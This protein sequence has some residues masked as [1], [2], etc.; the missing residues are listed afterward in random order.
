M[1]RNEDGLSRHGQLFDDQF[2]RINR[3]STD[4]SCNLSWSNERARIDVLAGAWKSTPVVQQSRKIQPVSL[5]IRSVNC[6]NTCSVAAN[7]RR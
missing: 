6:Q 1:G 7:Q 5:R 2:D 3:S 4:R